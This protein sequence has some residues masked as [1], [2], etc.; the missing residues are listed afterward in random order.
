[1]RVRRPEAHAD[2]F[3]GHHF[4]LFFDQGEQNL[5]RLPMKLQPGAVLGDLLA[6]LVHLERPQANIARGE[7][8]AACSCRIRFQRRT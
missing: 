2:F 8:P 7:R 3:A 6:M 1:V 5:I 4:A